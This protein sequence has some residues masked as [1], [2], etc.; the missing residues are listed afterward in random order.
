M[1]GVEGQDTVCSH[2]GEL[3]V[4]PSREGSGEADSVFENN[5]NYILKG[6]RNEYGI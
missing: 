5:E 1:K 4:S 6:K 3:S 2:S